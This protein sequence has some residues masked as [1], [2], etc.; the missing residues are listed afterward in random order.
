MSTVYMPGD[1]ITM[2]PAAPIERFSLD[3]G[4]EMPALSLYVDLD[5]AGTSLV[6]SQSRVEMIRVAANL[7]HDQLDDRVTEES[8]Q[9]PPQGQAD[10]LAGLEQAPELRALWRLTLALSAER[11]R[12]RG[13]PEARH[14]IDFSFYVDT[15][16]DGDQ[17]VRITQ[18]RR[19]A[20]LDRIVAELMILANAA[21]GQLLADQRVPGIYRSQ[22]AGGRVRM[23]TQPLPHHGLGVAQYGWSTS[24]LRRYTDLVNQRQLIA[25]VSAQEPPYAAGDA[26]LFA[27]ISAFDAR[28][29]AY[30]E[31]Q[32]RME[33]YW[34]LRWIA[35]QAQPRLK[36]VVVRD[37]LI[38]L[39]EAPLY[40]RMP[41]LPAMGLSPGQPIIVDITAL[42]ELELSVSARFVSVAQAAAGDDNAM[43]ELEDPIDGIDE[44]PGPPQAEADDAAL[45]QTDAAAVPGMAPA[46]TPPVSSET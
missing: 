5:E 1:K 8:L 24:P 12:V 43:V 39:A 35:Q 14:R 20:P 27:V 2:L 41:E 10:P 34:C 31:F 7:R 11:D 29:T 15:S 38:R 13:K 42:D 18:R 6:A 21:W 4:R 22:Q 23:S 19:D 17:T 44:V 3:A 9:P 36:A 28:Y 30:A 25:V 45:A 26:E 33:R 46:A 16:V 32:Q 37:E 40:L